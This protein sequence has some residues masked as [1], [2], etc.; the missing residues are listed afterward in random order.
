[1][2]CLIVPSFKQKKKKLQKRLFLLANARQIT[3]NLGF[4]FVS[5]FTSRL[6]WQNSKFTIFADMMEE[7]CHKD[8]FSVRLLNLAPFQPK[9]MALLLFFCFVVVGRLERNN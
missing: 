2:Y 8:C 9:S 7:E 4:S 1:M 6:F 3:E 5:N